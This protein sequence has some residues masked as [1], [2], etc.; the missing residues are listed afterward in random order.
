MFGRLFRAFR[1]S[2][3]EEDFYFDDLEKSEKPEKKKKDDSLEEW[4]DKVFQRYMGYAPANWVDHENGMPTCTKLS[5]TLKGKRSEYVN[6]F[7]DSWQD[8]PLTEDY[9]ESMREL[10]TQ[11]I[12]KPEKGGDYWNMYFYQWQQSPLTTEYHD[13][14]HAICRK[15]V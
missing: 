13:L 11:K 2:Y 9:K 10:I 3:P 5:P 8:W 15:G 14:V 7:T 4:K 1:M 12:G 6:D